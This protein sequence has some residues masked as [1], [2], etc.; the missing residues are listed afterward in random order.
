MTGQ[1]CPEDGFDCIVS[2]AAAITQI[3][4]GGTVTVAQGCDVTD[5]NTA[6]FD[7]AVK[8]AQAAD[9]VVAMMGIDQSVETESRD[10]TTID[11]PQVQQELL[12]KLL[13][14]G[15]PL[16]LVLLN[17]GMLAVSNKTAPAILEAG[18][19]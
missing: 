18:Y 1:I 4:T 5:P 17:G 8:A 16:I 15:K 14:V 11:L 2:P 12:S 10:R 6:G 3:N 13:A 7:D 19:K 9:V